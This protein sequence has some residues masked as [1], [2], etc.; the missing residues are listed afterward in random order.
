[1][2][3]ITI[4]GLDMQ[5]LNSELT[6]LLATLG[7]VMLLI[8]IASVIYLL[9]D[10]ILRSLAMARIGHRRE[11]PLWGLA[12]VP[13]LRLIVLGGIADDHDKKTVRRRHGYTILLPV[14][15]FI[16]LVA[17]LVEFLLVKNQAAFILQAL[18]VAS[19]LNGVLEALRALPGVNAIILVSALAKA[20][21]SLLTVFRT[22]AIYKL[23]ESCKRKYT[24]LNIILY[25]IVPLAAPIV[26]IA[27]SGSDSDRKK[28]K[29]PR[30]IEED[31]EIEE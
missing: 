20:A 14:L 23:L 21:G 11:I 12:W 15:L 31:E 30:P 18:S 22:I 13:G 2:D 16:Y 19:D 29:R 28:K 9:I 26:L 8:G 10:Y 6:Q 3:I 17:I 1:M 27:V 24:L 5:A 7:T 4:P 25:L